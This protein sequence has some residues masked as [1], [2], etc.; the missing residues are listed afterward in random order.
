MLPRPM[1]PAMVARDQP[2]SVWRGKRKTPRIGWRKVTSQ[3][4]V[5]VVTATIHQP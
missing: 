1:E 4:L 2:N 3:K 5:R